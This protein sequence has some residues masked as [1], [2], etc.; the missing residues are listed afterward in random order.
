MAF[1][2]K[3]MIVWNVPKPYEVDKW[4]V[5]IDTKGEIK[6]IVSHANKLTAILY[7]KMHMEWNSDT[8]AELANYQI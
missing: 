8:V 5:L 4:T 7:N 2:H 6:P 1:S 3:N